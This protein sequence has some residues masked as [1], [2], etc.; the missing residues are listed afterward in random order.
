MT[1]LPQICKPC[2]YLKGRRYTKMTH[3]GVARVQNDGEIPGERPFLKTIKANNSMGER[4]A[5]SS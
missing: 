4:V 1:A 5:F 2:V 3:G